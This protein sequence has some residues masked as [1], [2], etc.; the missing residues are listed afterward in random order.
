MPAKR[1][2]ASF[3]GSL[4]PFFR[5]SSFSAEHVFRTTVYLR[6]KDGDDLVLISSHRWR[7]PFTIN[8]YIEALNEEIRPG[9]I[10]VIDQKQLVGERVE[11]DLSQA[12]LYL[13]KIPFM[14]GASGLEKN[15]VIYLSKFF[16]LLATAWNAFYRSVALERICEIRNETLSKK[17]ISKIVGAGNGFTPSGDDFVSGLL[18]SF[19]FARSSKARWKNLEFALDDELLKRTTWASSQYIKLANYGIYDELTLENAIAIYRGDMKRAEELLLELAR[20]GHDSGLYI[21]L[22]LITG[23]SILKFGE[24]ITLNYICNGC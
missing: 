16:S 10:F 2:T 4:I 15:E 8:V 7:S 24:P 9:E 14:D 17:S 13:Q 1:L 19:S 20:R 3:F 5:G 22:G 18:A 12:N 23:F 21:W 11:I 6:K